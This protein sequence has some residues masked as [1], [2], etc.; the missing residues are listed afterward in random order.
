MTRLLLQFRLGRG[1]D[2]RVSVF[3]AVDQKTQVMSL[4]SGIDNRAAAESGDE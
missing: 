4:G 3:E 2:G 1:T